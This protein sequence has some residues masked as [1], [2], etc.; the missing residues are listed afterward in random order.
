MCV[1]LTPAALHARP[2]TQLNLIDSGQTE[3]PYSFVKIPLDE[4]SI[5]SPNQVLRN[6]SAIME[7]DDLSANSKRVVLTM[8]WKSTSGKT[9]SFKTGTILGGY[10]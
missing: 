4:A 9:H 2:L 8:S 3:P 6:A 7:I 1:L 5:Y 10:R